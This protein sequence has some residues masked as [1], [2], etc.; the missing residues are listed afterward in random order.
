[1]LAILQSERLMGVER[2]QMDAE[3]WASGAAGATI[4]GGNPT[5]R[6][7][8]EARGTSS[9]KPAPRPGT[10]GFFP[11]RL[12]PELTTVANL[13]FFSPSF[14]PQIPPVPSCIF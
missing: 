12:A 14:S 4:P 9:G 2:M 6:D 8:H 5:P 7:L 11:Q 10:C 13:L 1:M 3:P